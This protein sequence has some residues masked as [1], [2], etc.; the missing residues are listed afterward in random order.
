MSSRPR[1]QLMTATTL[2][3][4]STC[5]ALGLLPWWTLTPAPQST[6]YP[7]RISSSTRLETVV[8]LRLV[9]P[10]RLAREMLALRSIR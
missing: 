6:T 1:R 2:E 10:A 8:L 9:M 4:P 3:S 5:S 7:P